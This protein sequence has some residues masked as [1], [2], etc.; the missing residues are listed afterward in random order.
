VVAE[1]LLLAVHLA[2]AWSFGRLYTDGAFLGDLV[3]FSVVAWAVTVGT[4]RAHLPLPLVA[5]AEIGGAVLVATWLLFPD[6][7][8]R[9]LPTGATVQ[10]ASDALDVAGREFRTV[11]APTSPLVGFQLLS[12][13]ALWAAVQFAD[14]A[15]FRLR[16][17]VEALAPA[18]VVFV[19]G[20][21]LAGD[22]QRVASAVVFAAAGLA[23]VAAHR[24]YLAGLDDAWLGSSPARG[25]V[26]VRRAGLGVAAVAVLA[27]TALAPAAP[28]FDQEPLVRWRDTGDRGSQRD[29]VSP[30]VDLQGRLL[31]Q[32]NREMFNVRS[33]APSYWRLTSL[34]RFDGRIWASSAEFQDARGRLPTTAPDDVP[35]RR[36]VQDVEIVSL[37]ALWVPA[38]FEARELPRAGAPLLWD[39]ESSTLIVDDSSPSSDGLT[40]S[41]ASETPVLDPDVL[42]RADGPESEA[43]RSTYL[44]LPAT[45]PDR[46]RQEAQQVVAGLDDRYD[47]ARALQDFF[48]SS[49]FR[50]STDIPEGHGNDALVAFLDAGVGYCE[51]FAGAFAAMARAVGLPAR[52]AVGFT[53]GDA[54]PE[55]PTFYRVK[56]VHAHAWPEVHFPGVGWVPFEPTPGRGIPGAESYTGLPPAQASGGDDSL[57]PTTSTTT[58]ATPG[59]VPAT[60]TTGTIPPE[61]PVRGTSLPSADPGHDPGPA[62]RLA[63]ALLV[64]AGLGLGAVLVAPGVRARLRRR[65]PGS[66]AA[67]LDAWRSVLGP[68]RWRSGVVPRPAETHLE[69]AHRAA[70][71]LGDLAGPVAELAELAADAAWAADAPSPADQERAIELAGQVRRTVVAT[72]PRTV[73][74]RRRL[75]WREAFGRHDRPAPV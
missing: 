32:T 65:G 70:P 27:G 55:D 34:N 57:L 48:Q 72:E 44:A 11:V 15:A 36:V 25:A 24:A 39:A 52:V 3:A 17:T 2:V 47:R 42:R 58:T 21:V 40:Y 9:G 33:T 56:G 59:T 66:R 51:Q 13:L 31:R 75:S 68:V 46:V 29:T 1:I 8:A 16:A 37:S 73:R 23:Y 53:S 6:T 43:L 60:P 74:L 18:A 7:A 14:W 26:A 71:G 19:F 20:A 5:L 38:A 49:R 64:L 41:V 63:Q 10:A 12:G 22:R 54:D 4:R 45:L 61:A 69:V 50:Y 67:V 28:G 62:T 30:I 35:T